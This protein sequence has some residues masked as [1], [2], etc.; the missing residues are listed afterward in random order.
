[1]FNVSTPKKSIQKKQMQKKV[2]GYYGIKNFL[3][4]THLMI[5]TLIDINFSSDTL[6]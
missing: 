3:K 4:M 1:L 2:I 5:E 6:I